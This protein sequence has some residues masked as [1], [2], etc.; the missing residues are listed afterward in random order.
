MPERQTRPGSEDPFLLYL[1]LFVPPR[2]LYQTRQP[3]PWWLGLVTFLPFLLYMAW[4]S[5]Q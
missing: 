3:R 2:L 1:L 4:L 5:V